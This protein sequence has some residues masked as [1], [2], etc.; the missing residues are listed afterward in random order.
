MVPKISIN[1]A[2]IFLFPIINL[3]ELR[4]SSAHVTTFSSSS[5]LR[6]LLSIQDVLQHLQEEHGKGNRYP[7]FSL[8][9]SDSQGGI[10]DVEVVESQSAILPTATYSVFD[11]P[12]REVGHLGYLYLVSADEASGDFVLLTVN[13]VDGEVRGVVK[14]L[15]EDWVIVNGEDGLNSSGTERSLNSFE[16]AGHGITEHVSRE[17]VE[18]SH[19]TDERL[20][21]S[22][23]KRRLQAFHSNYLYQVDLYLDIDYDFVRNNG[24]SLCN[25]FSYVNS[26][27]TAANAVL[28]REIMSHVNVV[29]IRQTD[30]YGDVDSTTDAL[31]KMKKEFG[32]SY[33]HEDGVDLHYALLGKGLKGGL[34]ERAGIAFI[35]N[36]LCDPARGFGVVSGLKGGFESLNENLGTDLKRFMYALGHSFGSGPVSGELESLLF[37]YG[38]YWSQLNKIN[39]I[40]SW[41][42][43]P[44]LE[45]SANPRRVSFNMFTSANVRSDRCLDVSSKSNTEDGSFLGECLSGMLH[46]SIDN[47]VSSVESLKHR[48]SDAIVS[49]QAPSESDPTYSPSYIPTYIPTFA[50]TVSPT[51]SKTSKQKKGAG[52]IDGKG[53][54]TGKEGNGSGKTAKLMASNR[55]VD[56]KDDVE[57]AP[58][59]LSF[60]SALAA[61]PMFLRSYMPTYVPTF[62][63]TASPRRSKSSKDSTEAKSENNDGS[64]MGKA[65]KVMPSNRNVGGKHIVPVSSSK[66]SFAAATSASP[67]Y[68]PS[69]LQTYAPTFAATSSPTGSKTSKDVNKVK[70]NNYD[71]GGTGK[72]SKVVARDRDVGRKYD[73]EIAPS[74]LAFASRSFSFGNEVATVEKSKKI[75]EN[76]R[77]IDVQVQARKSGKTEGTDKKGKTGKDPKENK[78]PSDSKSSKKAPHNT[79]TIYMYSTLEWNLTCVN[80]SDATI[81]YIAKVVEKS[82]FERIDPKPIPQKVEVGFVLLVLICDRPVSNHTPYTVNA[83]RLLEGNPLSEIEFITQVTTRDCDNCEQMMFNATNSALETIVKDGS[84]TSDIQSNSIQAV[85]NPNRTYST[86]TLITSTPTKRPS[87][88]PIATN[89]PTQKPRKKRTRKPTP[90]PTS[91]PSRKPTPKPSSA[92]P[93][94]S[95]TPTKQPSTSPSR[96]PSFSPTKSPSKAPSKSSGSLSTSPVLSPRPSKAP[97]KSPSTSPTKQPSTSPSR[98]PSFS[99]TKSPSKAPS[100]SSGSPSISPVLSSRPSKAPSKSPSTSPTKQPSTSPSRRPSFSPTKSPSKAP[101]KSSGSPS[102]SPVLSS[103]PSKAPSESPSTSP[104]KQPS[105]S[106]SRRPSFSPTKSPSKAPSKS[107]GSPSNSPVLSSRPS[108]A[109]SESPSTSPTKQPSTSPS[110]RPSFS[111]TK[112]PSKAP[113]K[114]PSSSPSRRPSFSPSKIPTNAPSKNPSTSPSRRPTLSPS[115]VPSVS[116]SKIPSKSPSKSPTSPTKSPSTSPSKRPSLSPTKSPSFSPTQKSGV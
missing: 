4:Y 101:S 21:K 34:G 10:I 94:P 54:K 114:I 100:K 57:V 75:G 9:I 80:I 110:R 32:G 116:P 64:E 35:E 107:S 16:N 30:F 56:G 106:P 50:P 18:I 113:S 83:V 23:A 12:N 37:T 2:L 69:Y 19:V 38:G 53:G 29:S 67:T 15:E 22:H 96:R 41:L 104:T 85:I 17:E 95:S 68:F 72:A 58:T 20:R 40:D 14:R 61:S 65:S 13:P 25:V 91:P 62:V 79:T 71:G 11:R 33:W 63:P 48:P 87:S 39:N 115:K 76:A 97:S 70:N 74:K 52:A 112:S 42:D 109:P 46:K 45:S 6:T 7:K 82:I 102:I 27:V 66:L 36:S 108:K 81:L 84:I 31:D 98:R 26:L 5:H 47:T 44:N 1:R 55:K 49:A 8:A 51:R 88:F 89:P 78:P 86:F 73:I 77:I 3:L 105:T 59:K 90:I 99:P 111:P 28:E 93:F 103:R 60:S 92:P 24:G 43:N